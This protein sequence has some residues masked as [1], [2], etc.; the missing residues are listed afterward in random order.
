M[1]PETTVVETPPQ[2]PSVELAGTTIS[3]LMVAML[4]RPAHQPQKFTVKTLSARK[5]HQQ[6]VAEVD[7]TDGSWVILRMAPEKAQALAEAIY[8]VLGKKS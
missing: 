7:F 4:H 2:A 8:T 3:A 1:S 6:I 5:A